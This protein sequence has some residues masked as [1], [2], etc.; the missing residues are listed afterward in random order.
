M[1][2]QPLK[3]LDRFKESMQSVYGPFEILTSTQVQTWTP[4]PKSGGHN[5]RY[6]WTDA[7]GVL[8]FLTL[9]HSTS[10][11]RYLT[12]AKALVQSVHNTL[13]RT[14]DGKERLVGASEQ[15]PLRGGLRIGKIDATGPDGDGMYHHYLTLWMFAL[16][17]LAAAAKDLKYND[18]GIELAKSVHPHFLTRDRSGKV[19][20]MV[21]KISENMQK[22]LVSSEGHL[23]AATGYVVFRLLQETAGGGGILGEEIKDY[24]NLMKREGRLSASTD[25]LDLGMALWMCHFFKGKEGWADELGEKCLIN[26]RVLLKEDGGMLDRNPRYRLAFREFGTCLGIKCFDGDEFLERRVADVIKFWEI[27]MKDITVDDLRPIS[28][29]MN[30]AALIPG[31]FQKGYFEH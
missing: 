11:P 9:Y 23:D 2:S 12:F 30:A 25:T 18:M 31:A 1:T 7:F 16:N 8:N 21:W 26:A 5:G 15:H 17:R 10:D 29:V 3:F 28:M 4:P 22:V 14:R 13:G 19:A 27:F 6:L 24:E 20:G